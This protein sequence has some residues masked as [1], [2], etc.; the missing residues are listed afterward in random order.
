[1]KPLTKTHSKFLSLILRHAP[2]VANVRLDPNGWVSVPELLGKLKAKDARWSLAGLHDL[3]ASSDKQRFELSEDQSR[4]RARQGHSLSVDLGLVPQQPPELLFHGTVP[5]FI[6][7][8]RAQG[9]LKGSRQ[10]VHLSADLETAQKV[11][12]RRGKAVILQ[13]RSGQLYESGAPFF[14]SSNGVWLVEHVPAAFIL[15]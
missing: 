4:I 10:H 12:Q 7:S 11:A 15:G 14:L 13:V 6:D 9:L 8:I 5:K 1:M 3:V 2:E